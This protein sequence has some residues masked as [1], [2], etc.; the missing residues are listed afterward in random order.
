MVK[1]QLL[2][3]DG[4]S[5]AFRAFFAMHNQLDRMISHDGLHTNAL[6]AFNNFLDTIVDPMQPDYALVAWDAGKRT[7]R[8][9]KYD[10]YKGGRSKT[11]PELS[12]Q[13][14]YLREM[15]ELH[16]IKSYELVDYEADDII[17]TLAR[18]GE[19]DGMQVTI[20]TGDKDLTQL[21]TENTTVVVTIK[22]VTEVENYTPAHVAEK[23]DGLTPHQIIDMKALTGDTADNYPGVTK[24]GPVT[25]IKLLNEWGTLENLYDHVDELKKS[26]MKENLINDKENAFMSQDLATIRTE[27]PLEVGI[28]DIAYKGPD[29]EAIIPFYQN[30][31]F[32][33][34]LAKLKSQGHMETTKEPQKVLKYTEVTADNLAEISQLSGDVAVYIETPAENYHIS[35]MVGFVVGNAE[36]GYYVS[37]SVE[38]LLMPAFRD[39]L[40]DN[41]IKKNVFNAKATYVLL[42]RLGITLA[43]TDFDLL[44]ASYLVDTNEN[45]NDLGALAH[46]HEFYDVETDEEV[47]GKGAKYAIPADDNIYFE[48]LVHK[49]N[50]IDLLRE[51]IF[52]RLNEHE[53]LPLYNEI[54]LPLTFVLA[55]MEIAGITVDTQ[56]LQEQ[57]S[58]LVERLSE[59][60][61]S[62]YRQAG[63]E[64]N[65]QSP[66]QLGEVLFEKMGLPVIKKTKTGYSTAVDVLEQLAAQ[67]PIVEAILEYRQVA[68]LQQTYIDG[69]LKVVHSTDSKV[70]T[71]YLQTLTQT[72]RLSSV[73]PNL[74]NI[75]VRL[76][77]GRKIRQAFV[78]SHPDWEIFGADYSQI[79]L[80]V[81]AHITGDEHLQAAFR[82]DEDIHAATA[83]RIFGLTPEQ[84]VDGLMRRKAKAVNF[85]IVYGISDYGLSQ[86]IGVSRKEAKGIIDR[87]FEEYPGVK[88][89]TENVITEAKANGYVETLSN[90][91]RYLPEINSR[92]FNL[93]GFAER[94]AMNTPIQGSAADIIKIAMIKMEAVLEA[95]GLETTMLLQVH[96]EL[97]FEAPKAEIEKLTTLIPKVMDSAV[98]L[99]VPL[100]VES[101]HGLTW[102]DAK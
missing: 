67:A 97:I 10:D 12:E 100:K 98:Q 56:R 61:Q 5:L 32:K 20:I 7:L 35:E 29:Y 34:Q 95:E 50:A 41:L 58:K 21:A 94:T 36:Q 31:D 26:K 73:D 2:L 44:L 18:Q 6:V 11:P 84:E 24:I 74:Q 54:E 40:E 80:R 48:H 47:Y 39:L 55:K 62:I 101:H 63:E 72:G 45:N 75:P 81:L 51:K 19:A 28:D 99:D 14:P 49:A 82:D 60:E 17:G 64:F 23:Y 38:L 37:R 77:E 3:I 92:N 102:Y 93:R 69:L 22:G 53:Q 8:T 30:L 25:A 1:K 96:D 57:G 90:R 13:F 76:E 33:Q 46:E 78:P 52:N 9:D 71:R 85:G 79:E 86:S 70:H 4:N 59:L 27:A 68:K 88:A 43:G 16:G 42:N 66:K 15:V 89:W 87:Y 91:R 83:R 65:I